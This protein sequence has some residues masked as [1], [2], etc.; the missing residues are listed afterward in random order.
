MSR[1]V[2]ALGGNAISAGDPSAAGQQAA[3]LQSIKQL[4]PLLENNEAVL[5]HGNGP[6]VGALLL[7]QEAGNT[8][9]TPAMPLSTVGAMSQGSIGYWLEQASRNV[10][11]A[12]P[13][14]CLVTPTLVDKDDPAFQSPTKPIGPFYKKEQVAEQQKLH[15]GAVYKE[16]AGR[17]WRQVVA[18]PKP[19]KIMNTDLIDL[20][21][22]NGSVPIVAGGGGIPVVQ[23]DQGLHGVDAVIDK[24]WG[25]ALLARTL[26]ADRL[27][28]LTAVDHAY[29]NFGKE[30]Q[31]ALTRVS[32]A[33]M[34]HFLA[35][36]QFA[37][38]SMAPKVAACLDFVAHT[39]CE[40]TIAALSDA[41]RVEQGAGT[42]IYA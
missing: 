31:K 29:L 6:Q 11:L 34:G 7:Q 12:K 38:G 42:T 25:A 4:K 23:D 10:H 36:G 33:A 28:I 13:A 3:C 8:A 37:S 19:R 18:S 2:I 16:D 39:G 30:G 35:E 21:L 32:A 27:I 5:T 22:K 20:L 26:H 41:G 17:G 9:K 1:I 24:D 15:P 40:A 14:V